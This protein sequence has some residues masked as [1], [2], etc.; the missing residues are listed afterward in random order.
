VETS[1][2][3]ALP[4]SLLYKY[5]C[6]MYSENSGLDC[7]WIEYAEKCVFMPIKQVETPNSTESNCHG[8][9]G[10]AH[11]RFNEIRAKATVIALASFYVGHLRKISLSL[12][13]LKKKKK[14]RRRKKKDERFQGLAVF[15]Q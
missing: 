7:C 9:K 13:L 10:N 12:S 1:R 2:E 11:T 3:T 15:W 6:C 5:V 4:S 8:T 14:Q